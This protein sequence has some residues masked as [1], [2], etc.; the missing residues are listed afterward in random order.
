[1]NGS[2]Y[3]QVFQLVA[4]IPRGRV[5]TYGQ[6]ARALG[7]P[8]GARAV[9]WAM[10]RCPEGAPWHRVVNARGEFSVMARYPNGQLM[11]QALLEAEGVVFAS[12]GHIDLEQYAWAGPGDD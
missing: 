6:I 1:M 3:E 9:G 11:Q 4:Q 7:R 2:F 12:E 8:N 10:R 5:M